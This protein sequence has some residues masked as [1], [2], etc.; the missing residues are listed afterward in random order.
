MRKS[1]EE[2]EW[3]YYQRLARRAKKGLKVPQ[4][5]LDCADS[6]GL[7]VVKTDKANKDA[8]L[9]T[10]MRRSDEHGLSSIQ[11]YLNEHPVDALTFM[12]LLTVEKANQQSDAGR[13]PRPKT[14][15]TIRT[16]TIESMHKWRTDSHTLDEFIESAKTRSIDDLSLEESEKDNKRIF[17]L[18]WDSLIQKEK[19]DKKPVVAY[20]TLGKWWT[21]AEIR[22]KPI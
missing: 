2:R 14:K 12:R 5:F 7:L 13:K 17:K 22:P 19:S 8:A 18:T 4:E 11:E 15:P 10:K 1:L 9:L 21:I 16:L 3:L 20:S 6:L